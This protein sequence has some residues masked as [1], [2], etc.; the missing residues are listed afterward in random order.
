MQNTKQHVECLRNI[1]LD[2]CRLVTVM[3]RIGRRQFDSHAQSLKQFAP[4]DQS[5]KLSESYVVWIRITVLTIA[6]P[7]H[8]R[9]M[10][11]SELSNLHETDVAGMPPRLSITGD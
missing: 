10:D 9:Q 5:C 3:A 7:Y 6:R 11:S 4:R 2:F 8:H 1:A